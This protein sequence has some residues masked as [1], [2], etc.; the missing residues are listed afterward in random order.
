MTMLK[1]A[2]N[3]LAQGV[4]LVPLQPR[5]KRI[6]VGFG[7]YLKQIKSKEQAFFWFGERDCNLA[8]CTGRGLVVLDFDQVEDYTAWCAAWPCLAG[9][10]TEQTRNG[11][12]VFLAGNSGSGNLSGGIEIKGNGACVMSAPSVHPSGFVYT[13]IDKAASFQ[14]LP[15]SLSLLSEKEHRSL[16]RERE[17]NPDNDLIT[18]IKKRWDVLDLAQAITDNRLKTRNG[19]WWHGPCP[20]EVH[21]KTMKHGSLPFWVNSKNGLWGCYACN[22]RGDVINLYARHKGLS[23]QEA[24]RDMATIL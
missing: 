6:I 19:E 7:P 21:K 14:Q 24:V 16:S 5:S 11:L 8:V 3:W 9:T 13:A 18:R 1:A 12:H 10:Y 17:N 4:F 15:L 23:I 20:F 2:L 22:I